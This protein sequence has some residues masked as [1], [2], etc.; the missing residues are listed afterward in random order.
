MHN[1]LL[2]IDDEPDIL[3]TLKMALSQEDYNVFA[4][5]GGEAALEILRQQAIDLVITDMR[6]P[7]MDGTQ[8]IRNVKGHDPDIEV[9][10]LTGHATLE[11]AIMSLRQMGAYDYLTKPLEDLDELFMAVEKGLEKRRLTLE[12]RALLLNLKEKK[13]AL[14]DKNRALQ[15]SEFLKQAILDGMSST[16]CFIAD[17]D[18]KILW[19]NQATEPATELPLQEL[20]GQKCPDVWGKSLDNEDNCPLI[21]A[22]ETGKS[23]QAVMEYP[24]GRILDVRAEPVLDDQG[25]LLGVLRISDDI[26]E[27]EKQREA[28][29]KMANLESIGTLAA[30]IAHDFN[31]LVAIV[32]GN[33]EMAEWTVE[34]DTPPGRA[35][36]LAKWGCSK[37]QNL[38]QRFIT[39]SKGGNPEM[40]AGDLDALVLDTLP[41]SL[42][43]S[44]VKCTPHF[45]EDLWLVE[46]DTTQMGQ[47]IHNLVKNAVEAL[48]QGGTIDIRAENILVPESEPPPV[49]GL[50]SGRYVR[51]DVVDRGEG[52]SE[53]NQTRIFDPYFS[54]KSMGTQKG[55]GL[56]LTTAHSIVEKHG[57]VLHIES[58]LTI[59][60]TARV[61]LRASL[62]KHAAEPSMVLTTHEQ[63][64]EALDP[65]RVLVMDDEAGVRKLAK[66][67]LNLLGHEVETVGNSH[68]AV[69]AYRR[70]LEMEMPFDV[71]LLD[72]TIR[73][74]AG[75]KETLQELFKL[76]PYVRAVVVSG[77]SNDPVMANFKDYGFCAALP[78]PFLKASL[79]AAVKIALAPED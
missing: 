76:N 15:E 78:K 55:M 44:N 36:K 12:N 39:F 32:Q 4:A 63:K 10:V 73:G 29:V 23:E 60:T 6:M 20:I 53:E 57:G 26:T 72:L 79:G 70:S 65:K 61:Y 14:A 47:V 35:L 38:T 50:L 5:T 75:G 77:Y 49:P 2:V 46:M 42:S 31:N 16:L 41:L 13:E 9:I 67:M 59:G 40:K 17:R 52:I 7:G 25:K 66:Q 74:G 37:A 58:E 28:M 71:V 21:K 8:V 56:G 30:G 19:A 43:G 1:N 22:F 33:I 64:T 51:L 45:V 34:P 3:N 69:M 48:P 62:E 68:M 24:N 11:N 18:L 54:T 27:R